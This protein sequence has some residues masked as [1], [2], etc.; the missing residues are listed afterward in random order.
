[1]NDVERPKN[2]G[3][4]KKEEKTEKS[5]LQQSLEK[6]SPK[7]AKSVFGKVLVESQKKKTEGK[8]EKQSAKDLLFKAAEILSKITRTIEVIKED[9]EKGSGLK[10]Y[11]KGYKAALS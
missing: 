3:L 8:K 7:I 5:A 1:M 4:E 6:D 10:Y 9:S 2:T 11:S